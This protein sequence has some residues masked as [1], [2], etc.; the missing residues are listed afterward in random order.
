MPCESACMYSCIGISA[1]RSK[2][3]LT[4]F[5]R[6]CPSGFLRQGLLLTW[7]LSVS[8]ADYPASPRYLPASAFFP[9]LG[10]HATRPC[11]PLDIEGSNP[12]LQLC[13]IFIC[14]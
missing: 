13:G 11:F 5:V 12:D 10:S 9:L 14:S 1:W 3:N 8:R 4:V 7:N 2:V 6:S